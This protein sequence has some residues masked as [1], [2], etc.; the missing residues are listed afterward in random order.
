MRHN[1]FLA[2]ENNP[3]NHPNDPRRKIESAGEEIV[4]FAGG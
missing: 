2:F 3:V 1:N 4:D